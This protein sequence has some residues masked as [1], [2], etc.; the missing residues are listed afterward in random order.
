MVKLGDTIIK[1]RMTQKNVS[2][3]KIAKI[4]WNQSSCSW[5][6]SFEEINNTH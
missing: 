5:D 4:G 6:K 1:S 3:L 2:L